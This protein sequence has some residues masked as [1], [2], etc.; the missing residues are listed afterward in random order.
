MVERKLETLRQL[1]SVDEKVA[2]FVKK[3]PVQRE[4]IDL[5]LKT[6]AELYGPKK[7]NVGRRVAKVK[8]ARRP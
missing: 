5:L 6:A 7:G 4:T 8:R 3:G 1:E 2:E